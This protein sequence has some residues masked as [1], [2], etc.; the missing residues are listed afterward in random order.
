MG[1]MKMNAV[2]KVLAACGTMAVLVGCEPAATRQAKENI[3]QNAKASK[4][5]LDRQA[6][7]NKQAID[8]QAAAMKNNV[9]ANGQARKAATANDANAAEQRPKNCK[10][11]PIRLRPTRNKRAIAR[12]TLAERKSTTLI[13]GNAALRNEG[14]RLFAR[15][16]FSPSAQA[17]TV[18]CC[19]AGMLFAITCEMRPRP[20]TEMR[21]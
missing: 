12:Q 7:A 19:H 6:D 14:P 21:A 10:K 4:E 1:V 2:I 20:F 5:A 16:C 13:S 9:E 17:L 3:D 8:N 18:N 15:L 11:R